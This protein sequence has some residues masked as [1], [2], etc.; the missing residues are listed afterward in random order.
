MTFR[1]LLNHL[2]NKPL[3][4][5]YYIQGNYRLLCYNKARFLLRK[6]II[7]KF[8][9]RCRLAKPCLDNTECYA[10][11]CDTPALFFA[12]KGCQAKKYLNREPCYSPMKKMK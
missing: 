8:E 2:K 10:C 6:S 1:L 7:R 3:D 11:G 9:E 12:D 4:A 5:W